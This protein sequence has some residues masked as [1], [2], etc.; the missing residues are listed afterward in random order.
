MLH[1]PGVMLVQTQ[2]RSPFSGVGAALR[3][4]SRQALSCICS[5]TPSPHHTAEA[6]PLRRQLLQLASTVPLVA[7]S[8]LLAGPAAAENVYT[9]WWKSRRTAN[10][11]AKLLN[12]LYVAQQRLQEAFNLLQQ[13]SGVDD[14]TAALQL[15]RS[16]SL[17]CYIFE[18]SPDD[19]IETKASLLTQKLELSVSDLGTVCWA[20]VPILACF[21]PNTHALGARCCSR[22]SLTVHSGCKCKPAPVLTAGCGPALHP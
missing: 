16:S 14:L 17:N 8:Q 13:G 6:L 11:G 18:A 5:C 10:G 1:A 21:N 22:S 3:G 15:V 7:V 20:L 9:A 4:P 12:P 19:T 2:S